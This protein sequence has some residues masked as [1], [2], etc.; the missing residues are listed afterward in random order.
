MSSDDDVTV[1]DLPSDFGVDEHTNPGTGTGDGT[2]RPSLLAFDPLGELWMLSKR[3]AAHARH[4]ERQAVRAISNTSNS[5][6]A[7]QEC[8]SSTSAE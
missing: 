7:I 4:L 5:A 6:Q 1:P 2:G 3:F 8:S